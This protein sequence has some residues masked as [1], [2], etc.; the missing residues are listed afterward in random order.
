VAWRRNVVDVRC[1]YLGV[2]VVASERDWT[3]LTSKHPEVTIL[4]P[5]EV[6]QTILHP[7]TI[8]DN[9]NPTRVANRPSRVAYYRAAPKPYTP[10]LLMVV[11]AVAPWKAYLVTCHVIPSVPEK[12]MELWTRM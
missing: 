3:R 10:L 7:N 1:N 5:I 9:G 12:E 4:G 8:T 2:R 11:A 6:A